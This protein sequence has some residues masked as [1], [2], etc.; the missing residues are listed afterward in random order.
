MVFCTVE[1]FVPPAFYFY[2]NNRSL[3][4]KFLVKYDGYAAMA[5][6]YC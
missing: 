2:I 6:W 5:E 4:L 3:V 1:K